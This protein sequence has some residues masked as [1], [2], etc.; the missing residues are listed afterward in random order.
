[1]IIFLNIFNDKNLIELANKG[2]QGKT[3]RLSTKKWK[4]KFVKTSFTK[5]GT[6][7]KT[8]RQSL[9]LISNH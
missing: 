5:K 1:M 4:L 7:T 3:S 9:L 8:P 6:R 2:K